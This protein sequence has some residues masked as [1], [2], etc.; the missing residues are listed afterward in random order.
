[1]ASTEIKL[2]LLNTLHI[3]IITGEA[4][5]TSGK[6]LYQVVRIF[7]TVRRHTQN[8]GYKLIYSQYKHIIFIYFWNVNIV[9]RDIKPAN[10]LLDDDD[11]PVLMDF[12]SMGLA[13]MHITNMSQA[14]ALQVGLL[15]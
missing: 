10:V 13:V 15:L 12:G 1:M 11:T 6:H 3:I 7:R 4:S 8:N 2:L 5:L 9:C 14:L